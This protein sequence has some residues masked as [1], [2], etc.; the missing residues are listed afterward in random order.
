MEGSTALSVTSFPTRTVP[1]QETMWSPTIS[2]TC[3]L[4]HVISVITHL[5]LRQTSMHTGRENT[6]LTESNNGLTR[7]VCMDV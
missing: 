7:S 1:A 4:I 2:L 6:N 5:Q 3:S